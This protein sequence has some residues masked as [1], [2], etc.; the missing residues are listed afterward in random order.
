LAVKFIEQESPG[1]MEVARRLLGHRHIQT[2]INSYSEGK[3]GAALKQYEGL[4]ES[5][6]AGLA[7]PGRGR[8]ST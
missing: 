7:L 8:A 6:R 4:I 5:K 1:S 2:T 3:T